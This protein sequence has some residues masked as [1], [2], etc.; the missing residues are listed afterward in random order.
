MVTLAP[1]QL[2]HEALGALAP[3][4]GTTQD[5]RFTAKTISIRQGH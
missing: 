3:S 2:D 1:G 4:S 5:P